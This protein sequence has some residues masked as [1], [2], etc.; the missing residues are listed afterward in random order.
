MDRHPS[1]VK[2]LRQALKR[3]ARNRA[4][5]ARVSTSIKNVT[6]ATT[7]EPARA[8]LKE[9]GRLLNKSAGRNLIH[10]NKAARLKSRLTRLVATRFAS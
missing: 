1:T 5:K 7:E 4:M 2:R 3:N 9:A 10:R 6:S 8:A